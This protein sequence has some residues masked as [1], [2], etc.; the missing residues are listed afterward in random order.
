M[1]RLKAETLQ[2]K[3]LIINWMI[4]K[5]VQQQFIK[6]NEKTFLGKDGREIPVLFSAS[7]ML[8]KDEN[9]QGIVCVASDITDLKNAESAMRDSEEKYRTLVEQSLQGII[10][11]QKNRIVYA[12]SAFAAIAGYTIEE[13]YSFSP[14]KVIALTHPDDQ[15]LCLGT[16]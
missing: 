6:N 2:R 13:L 4:E 15:R 16:S 8:D 1:E 9:I 14:E 12:N 5:L 7:A 11:I 3:N 10:V